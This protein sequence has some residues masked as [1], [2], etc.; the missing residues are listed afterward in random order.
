M[1]LLAFSDVDALR[2]PVNDLL[3]LSQRQKTANK[4]NAAIL[5]SQGQEKEPRLPNILKM[6]LKMQELLKEK[7]DFPAMDLRGNFIDSESS[8]SSSSSSSSMFDDNSD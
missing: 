7:A 5:E 4:L 8:S 3:S 1:A 2:S 6:L